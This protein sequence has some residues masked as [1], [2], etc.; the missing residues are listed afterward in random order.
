[1]IMSCKYREIGK[2]PMFKIW[3]KN[4]EH[5]FIYMHSSGG[6]IVCSEKVYPITEGALC[7]IAKGKYH[8]T[9]PDNPAIYERS[10]LILPQDSVSA[11]VGAVPDFAEKDFVYAQIPSSERNAVDAVF[12]E[13]QEHTG[14]RH[15]KLILI[16]GLVKLLYYLDS[17]ATESITAQ[18]GFM[19]R[20]VSY[21]NDNI[22]TELDI[23]AIS[24]YVHMSKYYFCRRFK[25]TVGVTVMQYILK[26]RL[27][28]AKDMLSAGNA[29]I[30]EVSE[31]C[32]FSSLSYFCRVFKEETAMS[33]L[34]FRREFHS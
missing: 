11:F 13:M 20:A 21:I 1:M 7:F 2:D 16:S 19:D 23:D 3:H 27:A 28:L 32:G 33:P 12:R 24:A 5:T 10:K 25:E 14:K 8:Y 9:M 34:G 18:N 15:E 29:S 26:T 6:S 17:Y 4:E 30:G 31:H 22:F